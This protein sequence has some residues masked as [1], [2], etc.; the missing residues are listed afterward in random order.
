MK[1]IIRRR[2]SHEYLQAG[3]QPA[4]GGFADALAYHGEILDHKEEDGIT[5]VRVK[6]LHGAKLNDVLASTLRAVEFIGRTRRCRAC[7]TSS[8]GVSETEAGFIASGMT[9]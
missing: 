7:T 2:Y 8:S 4:A 5:S 6:L 1:E 3:I 9:E